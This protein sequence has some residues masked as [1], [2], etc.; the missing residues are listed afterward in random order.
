MSAKIHR[1]IHLLP[2]HILNENGTT[3]IVILVTVIGVV[4]FLA[5]AGIAPL[6]TGILSQLSQKDDSYAQIS[7]SFYESFSGSP[8]SP[9]RFDNDSPDAANWDIVAN[10][11]D[12]GATGADENAGFDAFEAHH[13]TDCAP[14]VSNDTLSA[15]LVTHHVNSIRDAVFKCKDHV[16]T[17]LLSGYAAAYL[18]PNQMVDFSGGEAV[19]KFDLSSLRTSGRD[20]VDLWITPMSENF[21][22]PL[23]RWNAP[24]NGEPKTALH[25]RADGN[26]DGS[27][28]FQGEI[29]RNFVQEGLNS[30]SGTIWGGVKTAFEN[31]GAK[32]T[33]TI[34]GQQNTIPVTMSPKRRD[35]YELR[36][37]RTHAK[38]CLVSV[39]VQMED[40]TKTPVP[41][42]Q[43]W[44][45]S[46]FTDLG[47]DKAVVQF[48]HH[49]Y[50]PQKD[51][52]PTPLTVPAIDQGCR[53]VTWHWDEIKL[54]PSV[55]FTI[56]KPTPSS[57]KFITRDASITLNS[58]APKNSFLR[59]AA[60]A[61]KVEVSFNNG[62][63]WT[64]IPRRQQ[65]RNNPEHFSNY[66]GA[67]PEGITTVKFRGTNAADWL[68]RFVVQHPVVFSTSSTTAS[69]TVSPTPVSTPTQYPS[70]SI[71]MS[72][73]ATPTP[74]P[75]PVSSPKPSV[76]PSPVSSTGT[77]TITFNDKSGQNTAFNGQY[78]S[79]V[80]NWGSGSWYLSGPWQKFTSKSISFNGG[81][82]KSAGFSFYT[83]KVLTK[84]D[85]Y[86]GG[87]ATATV[88]FSCQG[89]PDK[90]VM[91]ASK[92]M[93][94][95]VSTAWTTACSSITVNSSNGWD[96]NFD[97]LVIK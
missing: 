54:S 74:T 60:V 11:S 75:T 43:C 61:G 6:K 94:A 92:Q 20:W 64:E 93:L 34:N 36:L 14:P 41:T 62:Q 96:T 52:T 40:P 47:F 53:A 39:N 8:S 56:I 5:V 38:F 1:F 48:G 81:T 9:N 84:I 26:N 32:K 22:L 19:I 57:P 25:I 33:V 31:S 55:P 72:P 83:P 12:S 88:T 79:G 17:G 2:R 85:I 45:N 77:T 15:L 10:Q 59:F 91:V 67:I 73:S 27:H 37:T 78:P 21:V 95:G 90:S 68:S 76:S 66:W 87:S 49:A 7:N 24:Y 23:E 18:T 65:V 71:V 3:P 28:H 46:D 69:A 63:S 16:M 80:I 35:T 97:N 82:L 89:N 50:N 4:L 51:C 44:I 29:Y 30:G 13:G 42:E 86:N 58:P 70:P